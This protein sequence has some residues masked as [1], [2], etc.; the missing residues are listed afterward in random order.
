MVTDTKTLREKVEHLK[1]QNTE[2]ENNGYDSA[3]DDVL[4]LLEAHEQ[5]REELSTNFPVAGRAQGVKD[6]ANRKDADEM[7]TQPLRII[8]P[9][10]PL[11]DTAAPS[12]NIALF[13]LSKRSLDGSRLCGGCGRSEQDVAANGHDEDYG[14]FPDTALPSSLRTLAKDTQEYLPRFSAHPEALDDLVKLAENAFVLG[15]QSQRSIDATFMGHTL[16]CDIHRIV[17]AKCSCGLAE[18]MKP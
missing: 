11:P 17:G 13:W 14:R 8:P 6:A 1:A 12:N 2:P 5:A 9:S 4:A 15:Q 16:L 10:P 3:C 18:A 7:A